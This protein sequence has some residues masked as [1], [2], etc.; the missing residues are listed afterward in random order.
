MLLVPLVFLVALFAF[1][2]SAV[3]GGGAG[4]VLMPL[5]GLLLRPEQVP[6]ALSIGTA[7][8]SIGRVGT[9]FKA[10]R[11]QVVCRFV[12]LALPAAWLG[13]WMLSLM[14]P[15]YLDLLLGLFL[16]SNLPLLLRRRDHTATLRPLSPALLPAMGAAAGFISG[17]SGA[18]GLLFNTAYHRLGLKKEDIVATRAA[19]DVLL[20]ITKVGLYYSYGLVTQQVALVG[21]LVALAAVGALFSVRPLLNRLHDS[22]FRRIGHASACAAGVAMVLLA[23]NQVVRQ[24]HVQLGYTT[25]TT[26]TET[27]VTWRSHRFSIELE[28]ADLELKHTHPHASQIKP[29]IAIAVLHISAKNGI[30]TTH[31]VVRG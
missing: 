12:P 25:D 31:R 2:I 23:G 22:V 14:P 29:E 18:V 13:V 17:F 8:S 15:V 10:I 27:L 7:V 6:A 21:G 5:L 11:W 20:H 30:Y 26:R 1:T 9:F 16:L 3:S 28:H 4:L 19:N 24:D